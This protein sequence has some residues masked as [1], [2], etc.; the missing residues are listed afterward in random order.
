MDGANQLSFGVPYI[1]NQLDQFQ[2][3]SIA[4]IREILIIYVILHE[5]D[6]KQN[7]MSQE[8]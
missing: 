3:D 5:F 8:L 2:I 7:T 1:D 6:I 4:Y